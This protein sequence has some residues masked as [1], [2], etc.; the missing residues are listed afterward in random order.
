MANELT[1]DLLLDIEQAVA[2]GATT[3]KEIAE[4]IGWAVGTF[5]T[6][7][8]GT[9]R[10]NSEE[11]SKQIKAAIEKGRSR[12]R[13]KFLC[14]AEH[15]LMELIKNRNMTAVIFA[16]VNS[17]KWRSINKDIVINNNNTTEKHIIGWDYTNPDK[18][19]DKE[20]E[21]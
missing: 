9:Q 10:I 3:D 13:K 16:L 5:K 19:G 15:S 8:Y 1:E 7:K 12:Q 18:E 11:E 20:V 14:E 4:G 21:A 6:W 2:D 17:G